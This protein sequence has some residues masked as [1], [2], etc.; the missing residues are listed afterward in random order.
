MVAKCPTISISSRPTRQYLS[1]SM[2]L[3]SE[4]MKISAQQV[5]NVGQQGVQDACMSIRHDIK[6]LTPS[7]NAYLIEERSRQVSSR[8]ETTK[9]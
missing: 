7:I 4:K 3:T 2:H 9:P 1:S 6:K 8:F 5:R